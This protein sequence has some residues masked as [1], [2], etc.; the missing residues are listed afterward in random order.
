MS[1]PG[2]GA[3]LGH[4]RTADI[5]ACGA[6]AMKLYKP[7]VP[8]LGPFREAA[9]LAAVE[10]LGL[11]APAVHAVRRIDDRWGVLMSRVEGP[12]F[13]DAMTSQGGNLSAWL[14]RMVELQVQVHSH[15]ATQFV[16]LKR[17]LAANIGRAPVLSEQRRS[18]LLAELAA[19]AD[20][21]RLCHG[22]FHPDNIMGPLGHAVII[23]W[24]DA[25]CG[26]PAA[27]VCRSY[28]LIRHHDVALALAYV[29]A[30]SELSGT[31]RDA[32]LSWLPFVAAARLVE[33]LPEV[34]ELMAMVGG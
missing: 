15:P 28:V 20:G 32:I 30:Y 17:R 18:T 13:A 2:L 21:E 14:S 26:E 19:M 25:S 10:S 27:D 11:P 24:M 16:S 34:D 8:K 5:F 9:I 22:D 29:D 7:N 1:E 6:L 12:S 23:D 3:S 33:G 4:G 31:S